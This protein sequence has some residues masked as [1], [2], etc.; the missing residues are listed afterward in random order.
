MQ[1]RAAERERIDR[2]LGDAGAGASSVLLIHGEAG[3]GKTALLDYAAARASGMRVL[4]IEG[5]ESETELAF[6]G[7][8]QLFL[9][10]MDL[11]DRL[12]GPQAAA[13]RA[14][15]GLTD[16]TVRDRFIIGLAVLS[17]LSEAAGDGTL[18]CLVDDVQWLDQASVDAL[19]FAA[20]RLQVEGVVMLFAARDTAGVAGVRGLPVLRLA[21]LDQEAAAALVPDLPPYVQE[22]IMDEAQGNPLALRELSAA[23]T[24][25]QRAG[26]LS[27]FA[28]SPPSNRVQDAFL[29]ADPPAPRS[30]PGDAAGGR[31]GRH[32]NAGAGPAR[33]GR[34]GRGPGARRARRSHRADRRHAALPAPADQVRG[35]SGQPVRRPGRRAPGPG[36]GAGAPEH[37]H[38]RAWQLAAAATGPDERVADELERVAVWAGGRQALASASAAYER[39]AQLTAEPETRARRF[40]AAAQAAADAGQD[41]RGGRLAAR[42]EVSPRDPGMAADLARV[43]AV[44]ELGYGRPDVAGRMLLD[45]A[46]ATGAA[47]PDKLPALL[48]DALHAAFSAGDAELI[49]AIGAG[50]RPR[51]CWPCPTACSPATCPGPCARSGRW[52]RSAPD[53]APGSW[54]G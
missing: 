24:P 54:S 18:L 34:D 21:G 38:R 13:L 41:E 11:V 29:D 16:D 27:P 36:G 1:G 9:P 2:M 12:P 23:L 8:H 50:P 7:L 49:A 4:R 30:H 3:I 14:V 44:V 19:T 52:W 17:M 46:D 6:A 45:C 15:F 35:L 53:P 47:R 42:V 25:A 48:V 20:R 43:R 32:R 26:Q 39:A 31:R 51:R 5:L 37:A 28:L 10:I 33:R 22:R 40:I